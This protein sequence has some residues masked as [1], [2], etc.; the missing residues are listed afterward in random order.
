M[1]IVIAKHSGFCKGV[2]HAVDTAMSIDP[3][4]TFVLGELI[5]NPAVT[6]MV[7]RRGI[8]TSNLTIG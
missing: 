1:N 7:S 5:H 2:Q 6:E 4:N 8:K 3:Q